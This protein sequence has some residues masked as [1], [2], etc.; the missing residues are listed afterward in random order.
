LEFV[1]G[2]HVLRDG[3][4]GGGGGEKNNNNKIHNPK[5]VCG[6]VGSGHNMATCL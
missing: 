1:G 3:G 2:H 4:D 6:I 5:F